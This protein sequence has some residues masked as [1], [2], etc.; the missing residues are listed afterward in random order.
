MESA[1]DEPDPQS[2]EPRSDDRELVRLLA[3]VCAADGRLDSAE[4]AELER[5]ARAL[6]LEP[7]ELA[8]PPSRA[9]ALAELD[10]ALARLPHGERERMLGRMAELLALDGRLDGADA[11]LLKRFA[12]RMQLSP[13][14]WDEIVRRRRRELGLERELARLHGGQR[15]LVWLAGASALVAL[16]AGAFLVSGAEEWHLGH[17]QERA[18]AQHAERALD[19]VVPV[20]VWLRAASE[21]EDSVDT[22]QRADFTGSAFAVGARGCFATCRHVLEPWLAAESASAL[23]RHGLAREEARAL[24]EIGLPG[25]RT[26]THWLRVPESARR[27]A[28]LAPP[29]RYEPG[30]W[31][32]CLIDVG[33][34][35]L[36]RAPEPLVLAIE[37]AAPAPMSAVV[38]LGMRG[39]RELAGERLSHV[40][41]VERCIVLQEPVPAGYSGGPLIALDGSVVGIGVARFASATGGQCVPVRALAPLLAAAAGAPAA[42]R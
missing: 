6:G 4:K 8:E 27:F 29:A 38:L 35:A 18:L 3:A 11:G 26:A 13:F 20:R 37:A 22:R 15:R 7:A 23:A 14:V 24:V 31:D 2:G 12:T 33:G 17:A 30:D 39:S 19:S 41:Q 16:I 34:L 32:V 1:P 28:P 21:P 36:E 40:E 9:A 5:F 42:P 25:A 10:A